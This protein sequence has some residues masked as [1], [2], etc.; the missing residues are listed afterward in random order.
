MPTIDEEQ[1]IFASNIDRGKALDTLQDS[2]TEVAAAQPGQILYAGQAIPSS[3]LVEIK[4]STNDVLRN[5]RALYARSWVSGIS[6]ICLGTTTNE[7]FTF[8]ITWKYYH[9]NCLNWAKR[10]I[11]RLQWV[12]G[13]LSE[14]KSSVP[15]EKIGAYVATPRN[16]EDPLSAH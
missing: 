16:P 11:R 8:T 9:Q 1:N 7:S 2:V 13:L 3:A 10:N 12:H 4:F 15:R 14:I 5:R 6:T